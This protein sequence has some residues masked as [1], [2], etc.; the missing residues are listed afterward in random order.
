MKVLL[1]EIGIL[2][3]VFRIIP[4]FITWL[5]EQFLKVIFRNI[6]NK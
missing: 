6:K 3:I 5:I 1:I 4:M 2:L